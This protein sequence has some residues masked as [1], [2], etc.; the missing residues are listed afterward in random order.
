MLSQGY[1]LTHL[2]DG[3]GCARSGDDYQAKSW[4]EAGK[5]TA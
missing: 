5:V 4:F 3:I 2:C 1:P